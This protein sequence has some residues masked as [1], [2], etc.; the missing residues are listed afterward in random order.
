MLCY[1]DRTFCTLTTCMKFSGCKYALTE[2][3]EK[4]AKAFGLLIA[5]DDGEKECY[6]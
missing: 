1:K 6:E 4:D 3:V 2:Q 5:M